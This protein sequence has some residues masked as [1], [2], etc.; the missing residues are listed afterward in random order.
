[1]IDW[2]EKTDNKFYKDEA[3]NTWKITCDMS[4]VCRVVECEGNQRNLKSTL[5]PSY[6]NPQATS[7]S[8]EYTTFS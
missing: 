8:N 5:F 3:I 4:K 2:N 7:T 6:A 1:M